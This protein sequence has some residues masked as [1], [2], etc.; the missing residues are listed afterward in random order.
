MALTSNTQAKQLIKCV[1]FFPNS[2]NFA[3]HFFLLQVGNYYPLGGGELYVS[4]KAVLMKSSRTYLAV[5][6]D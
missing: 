5:Q 3:F 6:N 4:V 2:G 1:S